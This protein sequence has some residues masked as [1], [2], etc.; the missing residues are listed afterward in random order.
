MSGSDF[1]LD[2]SLVYSSKNSF[3]FSSEGISVALRSRLRSF[4]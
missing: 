3:S 4:P 1:Y 2:I